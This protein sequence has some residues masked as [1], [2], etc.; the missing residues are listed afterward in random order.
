MSWNPCITIDMEQFLRVLREITRGRCDYMLT[1]LNERLE[2]CN[3]SSPMPADKAICYI[4]HFGVENLEKFEK[5]DG[6][7]DI[8][9][10]IGRENGRGKELYLHNFL[11]N[12]SE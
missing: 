1:E 12:S 4:E 2:A 10:Y 6:R 7:V 5:P 11:F 3:G 8:R 9:G